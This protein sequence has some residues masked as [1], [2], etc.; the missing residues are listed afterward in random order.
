M[1]RLWRNGNKSYIVIY[2]YATGYLVNLLQVMAGSSRPGQPKTL[3]TLLVTGVVFRSKSCPTF[4]HICLSFCPCVA[5]KLPVRAT[6]LL[7][8]VTAGKRD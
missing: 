1:P 4:E 8:D 2:V 5:I 7:D 3:V 6:S